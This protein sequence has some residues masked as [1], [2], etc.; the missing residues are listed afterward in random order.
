MGN[1]EWNGWR[2]APARGRVDETGGD[3]GAAD[4]EGE[5]EH[6][7]SAVGVVG[8]TRVARCS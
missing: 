3:G 7:I 8:L 2:C 4:I 6:A 1:S 5:G